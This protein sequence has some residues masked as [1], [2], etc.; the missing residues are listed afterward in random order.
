MLSFFHNYHV[1]FNDSPLLYQVH[2]KDCCCCCCKPSKFRVHGL[3]VLTYH[4][5]SLY[6]GV[7]VSSGTGSPTL[8]TTTTTTETKTKLESQKVPPPVAKKPVMEESRYLTPTKKVITE[9]LRYTTVSPPQKSVIEEVRYTT[10]PSKKTVIQ[11]E[12]R[13]VIKTQKVKGPFCTSV[14]C[15]NTH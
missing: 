5:S 15:N 14:T 8:T 10:T 12:Y 2:S 9:E 11:E 7:P 1:P 3:R 4:C 6:V 13:W